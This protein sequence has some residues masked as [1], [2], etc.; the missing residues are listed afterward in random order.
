MEW[1]DPK[2]MTSGRPVRTRV[3]VI[4][5]ADASE[6]RDRFEE[7]ARNAPVAWSFHAAHTRLHPALH[8][9]EEAAILL[10]LLCDAYGMSG[11][12]AR[13]I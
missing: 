11:K 6:R 4:S 5:M 10:D 8:Y 3:I 9:D 12:G 1:V 2:S 13:R 7:R